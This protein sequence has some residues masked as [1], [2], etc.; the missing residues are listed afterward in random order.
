MKIIIKTVP[1]GKQFVIDIDEKAS[2]EETKKQISLKEGSD[3]S[4]YS[5]YW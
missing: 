1:E 2:V 5:L 3:P 4:S